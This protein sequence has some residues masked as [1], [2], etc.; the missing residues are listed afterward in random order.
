[1][2]STPSDGPKDLSSVNAR[3]RIPP[4]S[5]AVALTGWMLQDQLPVDS[6]GFRFNVRTLFRILETRFETQPSDFGAWG[7]RTTTPLTELLSRL[8]GSP[9]QAST[10]AVHTA[11]I[12]GPMLLALKTALYIVLCCSPQ[13]AEAVRAGYGA[14][15]DVIL[16][17]AEKKDLVYRRRPRRYGA[18][19]IQE[20]RATLVELLLR[21]PRCCPSN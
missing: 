16:F 18:R 15:S 20:L 21:Y 12:L 1:M 4:L 2:L 11:K 5:R 3:I 8:T 13:H 9:P 7:T 10:S 14:L 17:G 19:A 6:Y